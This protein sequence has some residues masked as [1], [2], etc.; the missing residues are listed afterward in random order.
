MSVAE[1][2]PLALVLG[3]D[4]RLR[5]PGPDGGLE[6]EHGLE[7]VEIDLDALGAI[8]GLRLGVGDHE[9]DR[10]AG[11]HDLL[12][13]ERLVLP[14]LAAGHERKVRGGEH[15]AD[16]GHGTSIVGANRGDQRVCLVGEDEPR[17]EQRRD[18]EVGAEAC[19]PAD[20]RFGVT[21]RCRYADV[22]H[23]TQ[24][25]IHRVSDWRASGK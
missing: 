14:A 15:G 11:V 10:L 12:A 18:G 21:P 3:D 22:R 2:G 6:V 13:G 23:L 8:L 7:L 19:G 24:P 25:S 9:R 1:V 17:V 4:P 5:R 16:A 20:L